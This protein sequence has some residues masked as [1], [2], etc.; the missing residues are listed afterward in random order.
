MIFLQ[1]GDGVSP[2]VSD[3]AVKRIVLCLV[4]N[5]LVEDNLRLDVGITGIVLEAAAQ[6]IRFVTYS[7]LSCGVGSST[8]VNSSRHDTSIVPSKKSAGLKS[9]GLKSGKGDDDTS[10]VPSNKSSSG[11]KS[12]DDIFGINVNY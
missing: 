9:S 7:L 4:L 2:H 6:S 8:S 5:V 12:G 11:L 10:I 3:D 1:A